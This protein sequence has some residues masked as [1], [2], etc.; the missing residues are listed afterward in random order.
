[1]AEDK[2]MFPIGF[3]L[4]SGIEQAKKG[5]NKHFDD[6]QDLINKRTLEIKAK[7]DTNNIDQ[8]GDSINGLN[9]QLKVLSK[10]F[11]SLSI[12]EKFEADGKT[13]TAQAQDLVDKYK[14]VTQA[15]A[16]YGQ[17]LSQREKA[18]Q[19]TSKE[20][21]KNADKSLKSI[22]KEIAALDKLIEKE[23]QR[24]RDYKGIGAG[25]ED[26]PKQAS[27]LEIL[28][29]KYAE[30]EA[31]KKA[32]SAMPLVDSKEVKRLEDELKRLNDAIKATQT[33]GGSDT[34][35]NNALRKQIEQAEQLRQK[36]AQLDKEFAQLNA[37][38]K[39]YYAGGNLT[40]E[41]N[42]N[43]QQ[44]VQLERQ[45]AQATKTASDA[46][47]EMLNQERQLA[48]EQER[49]KAAAD[50]QNKARQAAYNAN[51]KA[52]LEIQRMLQAEENS[53]N[54]V[55]AKLQYHN[56]RL[57]EVAVG[58][59]AWEK[60]AAEVKRLG[61]VLER[62]NAQ[63][64]QATGQMGAT[65]T[66]GA[67][68]TTAALRQ[69]TQ[70]Y[71][72]QLGYIDRLIRRMAVLW[73]ISAATNFVSK[74]REVTA[75]FE[76]QRVSLGAI[77]QDQSRANQLFSE[78][79]TFALQSPLTIM[80]LTKYTKQLAAYKIETEE[81]FDTTKRLADVSVGL[82]VS[83]DRIVL[84][85]G[86]IRAAGAL[87]ASE[88]RQL[89]EAGIP[90]V[91]ALSEKLS[92]VN[93]K[94]VSAS[95]VMG[96]VEKRMIS[97]EQVKEI[98]EDMTSAGGMFYNMQEKQSQTLFGMWSKLGD[99]AAVMYD[100]MGNVGFVN[101]AMKGFIGTL[102]SMLRNWRLL[103][104]EI[105]IVGAFMVSYAIK[106]KNA[107]LQANAMAVA[108]NKVR[109]AGVAYNALLKQQAA[110][111]ATAT[112]AQ[113]QS[114]AAK[115]ANAKATLDLAIAERK[116]AQ[117][118]TIFG[119]AW[120]SV[121]SFFVGNWVGL[122]ITALS[123]VAMYF[124]DATEKAKRLQ[125][126]LDDIMSENTVLGEQS[127][128][129]FQFL[130][131]AAVKAADGSK[132]QKDALDELHRTYK[133]MIPVEDM[134]ID[135]L[136]EMKGN[137]E[138]LT[139]AVREYI[140]EQS[141][142]KAISSASEIYGKEQQD[143]TKNIREYLLD[144]GLSDVEVQRFFIAF[145]KQA[146]IT[147][148]S[149]FEKFKTAMEQA[150]VEVSKVLGDESA[151][152]LTKRFDTD[153]F[154]GL[155]YN[156]R[157]LSEANTGYLNT[158]EAINKAYAEE[159]G[160][161]G[162][163]RKE[164]E[165]L[166]KTL[167][168]VQ[169]RYQDAK[170]KDTFLTGQDYS[171]QRILIMVDNL[172]KALK[173]AGVEI[174][175]EWFS[176]IEDISKS[177]E[178]LSEIDFGEIFKNVPLGFKSYIEQVQKL[179]DGFVIKD[180]TINGIR[181]GFLKLAKQMKVSVDDER[182]QLMN[183]GENYEAYRKRIKG[184][185][186]DLI[187]KI[188]A[189]TA[190]RMAM[191]QWTPEYAANKSEEEQL[192]K[193]K[194]FYEKFYAALPGQTTGGGGTGSDTRLQTL[195]EIEKSLTEINKKYDELSKKEGA[196]KA[197]EH[198]NELYDK[199]LKYLNQIA[200]RFGLEF[201]MPTDFAD[202]QKYREQILKVIEKLKASG[203]KGAERAAIDLGMT[204]STGNIDKLQKSV[205]QQLKELQDRVSRTKTAKDFYDRILNL[206]GDY[207]MSAEI[208][209]SVY[210]DTGET[211]QKDMEDHLR[212]MF[213]SFEVEVPVGVV[214]DEN[215]I[216]Y[217]K[218]QDYIDTIEDK[219]S[220][221]YKQLS[222]ISEEGQK[223]SAQQVETWFKEIEKAKDY[224]QKRIDIATNLANRLADINARTD[225]SDDVKTTL[226][227][228]F[229]EKAQQEIDK[230]QFDE[231]KNS[232][233]YIAM[234]QDLEFASK[235][236]LTALRDRLIALKG[237]WKNLDPTQVKE[238]TKQIND[239]DDKIAQKNPFT[240]IVSSI[241]QLGKMRS[242]SEITKD[243]SIQLDILAQ[244][245][246]ALA[247]ASKA[248]ADAQVEVKNAT[249]DVTEARQRLEDAL[250]A[251]GGEETPEVKA[252]REELALRLQILDKV[253][254]ASGENIKN[255]KES[256]DE[257]KKAYEEQKKATDAVVDE[258]TKRDKLVKKIRSAKDEIAKYTDYINE[259]ADGI[260]EMLDAFGASDVDKQYFEDI[261][262]GFNKVSKGGQ[263]AVESY[264]RFASGD[265]FGGIT[266]GVS[267]IGNIIGGISDIF[268]AG[269]V[270]RANKEIARQQEILDQLTYTYSRLEEAQKDALGNEY[271]SNYNQRLK[272]LQQQQ[273]A[274]Q[275]QAEAE[276]S[277]GKKADEEKAKQF[278]E[279]AR[280]TADEIK[281]MQNELQEY[282]LGT[283][284]TS[285]ARDFAK[286]WLDAYASFDNTADAIKERFADMVENLIVESVMAQVAKAALSPLYDAIDKAAKD[287]GSF[288]FGDLKAALE[289]IPKASETM[290][291]ALQV[292]ANSIEGMGINLRD[293]IGSADTQL[294]G[295]SRDI[296]TASEESINGLAQGI[297][298]QNF[299]IS[300]IYGYMGTIVQIMTNGYTPAIT[301]GEISLTDLVTMQN[302]HLSNLPQ[303]AANTAATVERCERAAVAC[304]NMAAQLGRVIKPKG[305]S[306][307]FVLQTSIS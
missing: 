107:A 93:G 9:A 169:K 55:N 4:D 184:V 154:Y 135:K 95:D 178:K 136:R 265:I 170:G 171:N 17:T 52:G 271:I 42:A 179:Y 210:G 108:Q 259:A 47:R 288:D 109:A 122:L 200:K 150:G 16:E 142:Q 266:A 305:T 158:M 188:N 196:T 216:D 31:K 59:K 201:K 207:E 132:E 27:A 61:A 281:G 3:D 98:F 304:E 39:A 294:T 45:L 264:A 291:N 62:L 299:Y 14:S 32:I 73:S 24:V 94:L 187:S 19:R 28:K 284:L 224:S 181:N 289:M 174:K 217:K 182:F 206:T 143:R 253:K 157:K 92:E 306:S 75:E 88:I 273:E 116:A 49:L 244:K 15:L 148:K 191:A 276:R 203:L 185:I 63:M 37:T 126:T 68:R 64:R 269:K 117:S 6:L 241:K 149:V 54:N 279:Q 220:E 218:L 270:R 180:T 242:Q 227:E 280:S 131:D 85:Y 106:Q 100:E 199:Q 222:K 90:I 46:Q 225:L 249:T 89:T 287:D 246:K 120:K 296:A 221:L 239:L 190:A 193:L 82:G 83:F 286:A 34:P 231:F 194:E 137:Y 211:L 129:N 22:E 229:K 20:Q 258:T 115:I 255:A 113:R 105:G 176:I 262:N 268:S 25:F 58:S 144:K 152:Y 151:S 219:E 247:D 277:K 236:T 263:Q 192:Q 155:Y 91:E 267:A 165:K 161:T 38:N 204:I 77:I 175:A 76:L 183:S 166:Q 50:K 297:T 35:M 298:T 8:F 164:F 12:S 33:A 172:K 233:M 30:I 145:E 26:V 70:E 86:Q 245:E 123:A 57:N 275:K 159:S 243:L 81:L 235:K 141:R 2:L 197:L 234:F 202:L 292:A 230:L 56:K 205:E 104:G 282:L 80:D 110:L 96:M 102:E 248:Y 293:L 87:R 84:A 13:L 127:V 74:L 114:I 67:S 44:R 195:N 278:E 65:A 133:N 173:A 66:S 290:N 214:T 125:N 1:M 208:T 223:A 274:Y 260:R 162:E 139:N 60:S 112:A 213:G 228:G 167:G 302:Q 215:V 177:P 257:A 168:D 103:A 97:F 5:I 272:N 254:A 79:K 71:G 237:Q 78:I 119:K 138:Q 21:Q 41:A 251:S 121:K 53:I 153:Q 261:V 43:L 128:R 198:T 124:L 69:T 40:A 134:K 212:E 160:L 232:E 72:N 156:V 189:L 226:S 101:D 10:A 238:L 252:A 295:I 146:D 23:R 18:E 29:S 7:V 303:I 140:S 209:M 11:N 99:A 285:A 163:A 118:V 147:S 256:L 240:T 283:D 36:I 307:G 130:A 186:D 48:N 250:S 301:A 111:E 300:G 51:R